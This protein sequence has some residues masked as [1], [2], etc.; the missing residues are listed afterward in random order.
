M[1]GLHCTLKDTR[2]LTAADV[3]ALVAYARAHAAELANHVTLRHLLLFAPADSGLQ[4]HVLPCADQTA[5][6][7][8]FDSRDGYTH[9]FCAA[10]DVE[11]LGA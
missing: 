5:C 9:L 6:A 10:Y 8:V 3:C 1:S 2:D 7:A 11:R 4:W